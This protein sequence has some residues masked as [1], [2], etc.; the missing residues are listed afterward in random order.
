MA[1][2]MQIPGFSLSGTETRHGDG[3]IIQDK[4]NNVLVMDGFDGSSPS[5]KLI[6]IL[7]SSNF[8]DINLFLS[9]PHYDH[10]KGLTMIM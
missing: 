3:L 1:L 6:S 4:N 2:T 9:H 8:K 7:K 5:T 10:Y